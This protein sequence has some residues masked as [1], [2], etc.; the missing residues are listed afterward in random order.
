MNF[1]PKKRF[2]KQLVTMLLDSPEF[3][4]QH[5][6]EE[7]L[8]PWMG[9]PRRANQYNDIVLPLSVCHVRCALKAG[10]RQGEERGAGK[11]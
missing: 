10:W 4:A 7:A 9:Q 3:G 2:Q 5:L 1:W 8:G 6:R 11:L